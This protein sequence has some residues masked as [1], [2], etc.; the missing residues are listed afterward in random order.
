VLLDP[1]P[2]QRA[3]EGN[4]DVGG[5]HWKP[6]VLPVFGVEGGFENAEISQTATESRTNFL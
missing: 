6:R 3:V 2:W 5:A 1:G 4:R